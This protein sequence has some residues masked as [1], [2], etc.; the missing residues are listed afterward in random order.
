M[1]GNRQKTTNLSLHP[2]FLRPGM[3]RV[4]LSEVIAMRLSCPPPPQPFPAPIETGHRELLIV[5]T[6]AKCGCRQRSRGAALGQPR[7]IWGGGMDGERL[8]REGEGASPLQ[9]DAPGR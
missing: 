4:G 8:L 2:P 5:W 7:Q 1:Q 3:F 6:L 9:S